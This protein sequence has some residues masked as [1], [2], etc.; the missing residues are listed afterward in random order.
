MY[1]SLVQVPIVQQPRPSPPPQPQNDFSDKF[2]QRAGIGFWVDEEEMRGKGHYS[3][4][5][6]RGIRHRASD[7]FSR[8]KR[9]I[10]LESENTWYLG[11]LSNSANLLNTLY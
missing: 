4:G 8:H 1:I 9:K 3:E 7:I 2:K 11:Q 6:V 10:R 5:G